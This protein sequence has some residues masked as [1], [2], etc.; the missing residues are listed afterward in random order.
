M[1][2][3]V[4]KGLTRTI[5][6]TKNSPGQNLILRLAE[7]ETITKVSDNTFAIN[8]QQY[9]LQLPQQDK[10]KA[11]IKDFGNKKELIIKLIEGISQINYQVL[12]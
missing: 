6:I 4:G 7:G 10:V 3:A 9:Y 1:P 12:W 2:Y 8:N 5:N 11:E